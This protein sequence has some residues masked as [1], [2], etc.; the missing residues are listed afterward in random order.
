MKALL[1]IVSA[2]LIISVANLPIGYYT[3][4]RIVVTLCAVRVVV[5]EI[6]NGLNF[7]VIACGLIGILFNP[8]IPVYLNKKSAWMPIDIIAGLIFFIKALTF[9]KVQK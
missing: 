2:L 7:W 1:F 3:L 5:T 4:L 9:K 8:L 6:K